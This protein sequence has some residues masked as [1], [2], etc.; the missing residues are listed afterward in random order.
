MNAPDRLD[1]LDGDDSHKAVLKAH[2]A[3]LEM[4]SARVACI[5]PCG[6]IAND[7]LDDD[8]TLLSAIQS[9]LLRYGKEGM[10]HVTAFGWEP[11]I[12]AAV[13]GQ[14]GWDKLVDQH[15]NRL[16]A[17]FEL[18]NG[19]L[20]VREISL[21]RAFWPVGV[22][23]VIEL[24]EQHGEVAERLCVYIDGF[25]PS[26]TPATIGAQVTSQSNVTLPVL[27]WTASGSK[28]KRGS[29]Y[30]TIGCS[31]ESD[32][33][34]VCKS[35][36][37]R[38]KMWKGEKDPRGDANRGWHADVGGWPSR[39]ESVKYGHINDGHTQNEPWGARFADGG[40]WSEG[41]GW[42]KDSR[43]MVAS[44]CDE[45]HQLVQ[46]VKD[47]CSS[48]FEVCQKW[49]QFCDNNC[50]GCRN[51]DQRD[52]A[53]LKRFKEILGQDERDQILNFNRALI[54]QQIIF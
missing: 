39:E 35:Y 50:G 28:I 15:P 41:T 4:S 18:S 29:K 51:P 47:L 6:S 49:L 25:D 31:N 7:K 32:A 44:D 8:E 13:E 27:P 54:S 45:H 52:S 33:N 46:Q 37:G 20:E 38:A 1:I 34:L 12:R 23:S 17:S 3:R 24:C 48:S 40:R 14:G 9:F 26:D 2:S 21:A 30:A 10:L 5:A 53:M 36:P 43:Y 11:R 42:S 22:K 16:V 19:G